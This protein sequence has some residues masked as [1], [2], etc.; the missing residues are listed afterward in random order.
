MVG[1]GRV[2]F[3]FGAEPFDVDV[4]G[5]GVTYVLRSPYPVDE[6]GAG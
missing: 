2:R 5:F 4:E 1:C 6:L 3:D